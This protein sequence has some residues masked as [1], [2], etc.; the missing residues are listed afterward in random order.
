[1]LKNEYLSTNNQNSFD[2]N[3]KNHNKGNLIN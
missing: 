3:K 2:K 1:M